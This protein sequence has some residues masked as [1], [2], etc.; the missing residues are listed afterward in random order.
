[1]SVCGEVEFYTLLKNEPMRYL[2]ILEHN[3]EAKK[4]ASERFGITVSRQERKGLVIDYA[5]KMYNHHDKI[6]GPDQEAVETLRFNL[7][8]ILN[9]GPSLIKETHPGKRT[10]VKPQP[11][12]S[13]GNKKGELNL[14]DQLVLIRNTLSLI[15][16]QLDS[17]ISNQR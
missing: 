12:K 5:I 1:M 4:L 3:D 10:N 15:Q 9:I 2:S 17:I 14:K 13:V 7:T 11:P 8:S 16:L 6:E